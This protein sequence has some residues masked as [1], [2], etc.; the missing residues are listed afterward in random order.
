M[1]SSHQ[2]YSI[3]KGA[4][5]TFD[6]PRAR[7]RAQTESCTCPP[8]LATTKPLFELLGGSARVSACMGKR[9]FLDSLCLLNYSLTHFFPGLCARISYV[10]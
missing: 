3:C 8:I 6:G 9:L 5:L 1:S 2:S 10:L 7:P 4:A